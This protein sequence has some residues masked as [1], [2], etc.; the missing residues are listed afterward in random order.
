VFPF[1]YGFLIASDAWFESALSRGRWPTVTAAAAATA[2]LLGW[3]A[4]A[5]P[6]AVTAP[7]TGYSARMGSPIPIIQ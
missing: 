7:R 1:A 4:A 6:G 5:G 3:T 2:G